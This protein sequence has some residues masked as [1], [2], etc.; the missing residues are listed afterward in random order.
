[1]TSAEI[2]YIISAVI[3]LILALT[4]W[5]RAQTALDH[6]RVTRDMITNHI[7][8]QHPIPPETDKNN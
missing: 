3:P 8:H 7:I 2:A 4:A 6:A 1:M 5:L